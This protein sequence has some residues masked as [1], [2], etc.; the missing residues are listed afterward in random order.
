M[1]RLNGRAKWGPYLEAASL[2]KPDALSSSLLSVVLLAV[3]S[4][5]AHSFFQFVTSFFL[6]YPC[7]TSCL[8]SKHF[9]KHLHSSQV[10]TRC[11]QVPGVWFPA[12]PGK[13]REELAADDSLGTLATAPFYHQIHRL[14][15]LLCYP[16]LEKNC[17]DLMCYSSEGKGILAVRGQGWPPAWKGTVSS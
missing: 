8:Y 16:G 10:P 6:C 15:S 12:S 2:R 13:A 4:A 5:C 9:M 14:F 17:Q 1:W 3:D 7:H 11:G